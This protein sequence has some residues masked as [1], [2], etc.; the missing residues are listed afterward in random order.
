M[1]SLDAL[2]YVGDM[3]TYEILF[4][5]LYGR[6]IWGDLTGKICWK[7]LQVNQKGPCPFCTNEKLLDS[8]GNPAEILI[9]EFQ[10]TVNGK[11]YE[12]HDRAIR[13]TD[14]R[15]VR[16]EIASDITDRKRAEEA[17]RVSEERF[18]G[19]TERISGFNLVVDLKGHPIFMSP[20]VTSILGFP[21]ES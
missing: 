3:K 7:S 18:R 12:C 9:W 1:D 10:N 14:G 5:N 21:S 6:K 20:S 2:V 11:V 13:W 4:V 16:I 17:L 15:I 19:I 8:D